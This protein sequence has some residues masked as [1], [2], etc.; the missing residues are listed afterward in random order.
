M[1]EEEYILSE[2]INEERNNCTYKRIIIIFLIVALTLILVSLLVFLIINKIY[3][4]KDMKNMND[5]NNINDINDMN[6]IID[7]PIILKNG[8]WDGYETNVGAHYY[9]YSPYSAE[10]SKV[11]VLL[12]LPDSINTNNGKRNAYISFGIIGINGGINIGLINAGK[13]W[14][15][16]HYFIKT[17]EMFCYNEYCSNDETEF[18]EIEIEVTQERK[19][20]AS[21]TLKNST[22]FPLKN[23]NIEIDASDILEYEN[24]KVKVRFFRFASLV[25]VGEDDQND[26]TFVKN[27]KFTQLSIVKNNITES[28]GISGNNIEISWLISSKRI[29]VEYRKSEEKFSIIHRKNSF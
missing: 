3:K 21:F 14:R 11:R 13:G 25:P 19:L 20:L 15:P 6:D 2:N 24:D 16:F 17:Q 4:D 5:M 29:K 9:A 28:W 23:L 27:G 10:Y 12:Q 8:I 22:L 7:D 1:N 26:G 18:I